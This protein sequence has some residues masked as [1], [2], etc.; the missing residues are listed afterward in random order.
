[1]GIR[2]HLV[3]YFLASWLDQ[4]EV[5]MH[6]LCTQAVHLLYYIIKSS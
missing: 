2:I 3:S 5:I 1:M 6:A 4:E